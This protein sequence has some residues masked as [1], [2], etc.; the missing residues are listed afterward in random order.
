M[1]PAD[2]SALACPTC[3]GPLAFEGEL[4]GHTLAHGR[5]RCGSCARLWP[6]QDGLPRLVDEAEVR[7]LDR[8]MRVLYD[9]FAVLHDPAVRLL[10]PLLQGSSEAALRTGYIRRLDLPAVVP[11]ARGRP[12]RILEVGIGAGGNLPLV[13]RDLPP[14]IPVELWGLDLSEGMLAQ[15]SARL[16]A[17]PGPPVRLLLADAHAL[18]F[19]DG[20]FDRV[21]HVGGLNGFRDRRRALVEMARV[22][23][24]GTPIVVVDERLDPGRSHCLYYQLT[25]RA[26]TLYDPLPSSPV[27]EL[28]AGAERVID[29]QVSRFYYCLTFRMPT[30]S[31]ASGTP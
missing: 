8:W 29:E 3:R 9:G 17:N 10:L 20:S 16:A 26:L 28:P 13:L 12:L 6:V 19:P 30:P 24:P 2:V 5:L 22:A 18:P 21:F 7:G 25:F 15:C 4:A 1:T 23:W 27:T 14:G 11:V 31:P